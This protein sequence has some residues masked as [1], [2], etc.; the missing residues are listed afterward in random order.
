MINE[1]DI[2]NPKFKCW[3]GESPKKNHEKELKMKK[4][5]LLKSKMIL[6][7]QNIRKKKNSQGQFSYCRS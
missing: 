2:K 6:N 5:K 7:K 4:E 3:K 1:K